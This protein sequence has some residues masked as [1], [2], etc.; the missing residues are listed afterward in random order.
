MTVLQLMYKFF[1]TGWSK[2]ANIYH[3]KLNI[4]CYIN[5][6]GTLKFKTFV[7]F[8]KRSKLRSKYTMAYYGTML[9]IRGKHILCSTLTA[10]SPERK[11]HVYIE[12]NNNFRRI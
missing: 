1:G 12:K 4:L 3:Y 10:S 6:H 7:I 2:H 8:K 11:K 9:G 5:D